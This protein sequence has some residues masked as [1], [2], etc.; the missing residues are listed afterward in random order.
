MAAFTCLIPILSWVQIQAVPPGLSLSAS[1]GL[2]FFGYKMGPMDCCEEQNKSCCERP[3]P[4]PT[5]NK[6]W[7][8][9]HSW[10]APPQIR[11]PFSV[12]W[13]QLPRWGSHFSD[14]LHVDG[15]SFLVLTNGAC[16]GCDTP[17]PGRDQEW[18]HLA[19]SLSLL[20]AE[21]GGVSGLKGGRMRM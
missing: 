7:Q 12:L 5:S 8:Q 16:T 4:E 21:Q 2:P 18:A 3:S 9:R 17:R 11:D 14:L 15:A 13:E 6:C 20:L 10:P 1:L 19:R